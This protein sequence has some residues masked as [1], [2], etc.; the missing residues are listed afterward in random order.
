MLPPS[1]WITGERILPSVFEP[2]VLTKDRCELHQGPGVSDTLS[3]CETGRAVVTLQPISAPLLRFSKVRI[4][5]GQFKTTFVY[6]CWW[7][8]G[9]FFFN[10]TD[11][12]LCIKAEMNTC[13]VHKLFLRSGCVC[14]GGHTHS[15]TVQI[16]CNQ[17]PPCFLLHYLQRV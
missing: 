8:V 14:V 3:H 15:F 5:S 7:V 9:C 11:E 10:L 6:C 12:P 16:T 13:E 2:C 1:V 17:R 4:T